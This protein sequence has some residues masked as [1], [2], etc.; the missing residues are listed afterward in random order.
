M[1][2]TRAAEAESG[3]I[4][5]GTNEKPLAPP[6]E[7]KAVVIVLHQLHSNPGH[8]GQWLR[9]RGYTLDIRRPRYGDPLP[10]TLENHAGAVIFG[11]PMSA[12]DPEE[13]I[14]RETEWIGVALK[15]RKPFL[16]IC[17]GA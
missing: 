16:G 2:D 13:Y 7:R 15:E 6:Q 1:L 17:L 3:A 5:L 8:V 4:T 11:G 9:N 10:E 14:K 12:N